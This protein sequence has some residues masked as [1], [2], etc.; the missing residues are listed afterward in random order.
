MTAAV[1]TTTWARI[2][3]ILW[4]MAF[5]ENTGQRGANNSSVSH[6]HSE[7]Q[8]ELAPDLQML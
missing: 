5:A 1:P 7:L 8:C 2:E 4:N 3:P 6:V